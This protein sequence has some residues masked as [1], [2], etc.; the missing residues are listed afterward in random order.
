M[1]KIISFF[2]HKGGVG[3]TTLAYNVAWDLS[4]R[5]Q[6]VLMIDGDPQANLTEITL[7]NKLFY[8][9]V[10]LFSTEDVVEY[11]P[12]FL[13]ENNIYEYFRAYI[14]PELNEQR[15]QI[16]K[17]KKKNNLDLLAG[18]IRL[19]ELEDTISLAVS[20]VPGLRDIPNRAYQAL[21]DLG[22][23]YDY[24][25]L[26]LS[27]ALSATN[28]LFVELSDY[29]IVP[30][31]PS[32]FSLQ[33]LDNLQDIFRNW[34]RKLSSFDIFSRGQKSLPVMLGIVC[35]NYRPYSKAGEKNTTSAARFERRMNELNDSAVTLANSLNS[36]GMALLPEQF[37]EIFI[38]CEPY[39]IANLP[40]YNQLSTVSEN[41]KVP[42]VGLTNS[43]LAKNKLNLPQYIQKVSDFKEECAQIVTGLLKLK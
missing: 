1:A 39:R 3:K 6:R 41:E 25:L 15:P 2:N 22:E 29:F 10:D 21:Q 23:D 32:I 7:D 8:E 4:E 5:G 14:L 20:N 36:F 30:V 11:S 24:I 40:D 28:Q 33:A 16:Q 13:K 42:V 18:S 12:E 34:N 37:K 31:N 38:H 9:E 43:L 35:Q 26:D 27:P 17:F 19:A